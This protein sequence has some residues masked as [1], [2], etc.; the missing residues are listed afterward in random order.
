MI[1]LGARG[2]NP[3]IGRFDRVDPVIEG[4]E[5]LSLYHYSFNNPVRF[6]D[7]DGLMGE[8]CCQKVIDFV[9]GATLRFIDNNSPVPTSLDGGGYRGSAYENGRK[10]GDG[11]SL[12]SGG[13]QVVTGGLM[14]L[15][16]GGLEIA[17]GGT[18]SP[19][20]I[21]LGMVAFATAGNGANTISKALGNLNSEGAKNSG[22]N[23]K[24]NPY[25][26]MGDK[27]LQSSKSTYEKLIKEHKEKL[28]DF[29]SNPMEKSNPE[30]LKQ[31]K[32]GGAEAVKK[33]LQGRVDALN[34]QINKQEGELKK[35]NSEIKT[36]NL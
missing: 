36:R 16:A 32:K 25:S 21:P 7:A 13:A 10:F 29:K 6:S 33:F 30:K 3:T 5:Q 12:L 34:K 28:S 11:L 14:A 24:S 18:A 2:Y 35:I 17:S 22:G 15:G 23:E 20:A 19:M 8:S 26:K 27:Q 1:R 9:A 31:A 4:Q